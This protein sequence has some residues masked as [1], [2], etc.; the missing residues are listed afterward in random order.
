MSDSDNNEEINNDENEDNESTNNWNAFGIGILNA[1]IITLLCAILGTNFT[2]LTRIDL[3]K[4]FPYNEKSRPYHE[5]NTKT[6]LALPHYFYK[7]QPKSSCG[8][9]IFINNEKI[10]NNKFILGFFDYGFPYT[11]LNH[12]DQENLSFGDKFLDWFANIVE[13]SYIWQRNSIQKIFTFIDGICGLSK[14][15]NAIPF[16]IGLLI[17]PIIFLLYGHLWWLVT[18]FSTFFNAKTTFQIIISAIGC[19]F[20]YTWAI[21]L[22]LNFVQ[23][24]GLL[25]KFILLPPFMNWVEWKKILHSTD[26]SFVMMFIFS[27]FIISSAFSNLEIT[28]SATIMAVII[29]TYASSL[30]QYIKQKN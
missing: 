24:F 11:W 4:I 27:I 7:Q 1:V 5:F 19:L 30:Y 14:S 22:G 23:A 6:Y 21:A 20:A 8:D 16:I 15:N 3:D 18:M 25:F 12:Y 9:S 26:V 2:F 28:I 17:I 29:F 10:T 13:N